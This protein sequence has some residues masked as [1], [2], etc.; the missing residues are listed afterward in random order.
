MSSWTK[1]SAPQN[2]VRGNNNSR[3]TRTYNPFRKSTDDKAQKKG[4]WDNVKKPKKRI[5]ETKKT[6]NSGARE[7]QSKIENLPVEEVIKNDQIKI[8]FKK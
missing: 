5:V 2:K 3:N 8:Q 6:T 1:K 4:L 7:K